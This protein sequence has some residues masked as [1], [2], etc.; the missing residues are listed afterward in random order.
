MIIPSLEAFD[1]RSIE[2]I[3]LNRKEKEK[4]ISFRKQSHN[5]SNRMM[6]SITQKD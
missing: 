3:E 6:K 5:I 1:F 4:R 2:F